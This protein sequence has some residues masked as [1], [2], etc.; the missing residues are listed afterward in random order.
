MQVDTA[1]VARRLFAFFLKHRKCIGKT[2]KYNIF[3]DLN[4]SL[5]QQPV[6]ILSN[7]HFT[8]RTDILRKVVLK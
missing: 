6:I 8:E 4:Y 3:S 7:M 2:K 1:C 5:L